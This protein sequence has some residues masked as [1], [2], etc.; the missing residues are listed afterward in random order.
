MSSIGYCKIMIS[1]LILM[2]LN[3]KKIPIRNRQ[4]CFY[5]V[6][7][8]YLTFGVKA[9]PFRAGMKHRPLG[10]EQSLKKR[11]DILSKK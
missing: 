1:I 7:I 11:F 6:L 4:L 9:S 2:F 3:V 5:G 10:K 8:I